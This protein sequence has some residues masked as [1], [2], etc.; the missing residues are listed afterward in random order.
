MRDGAVAQVLAH[1]APILRL[2]LG[3]IVAVPGARF[4]VRFDAQLV[5]YLRDVAVDVLRAIVGMK[6]LDDEGEAVQER[7]QHRDEECLA[8]S[9]AGGDPCV[10]SHTVYGIDRVDA[11]DAVPIALMNAVHA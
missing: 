2:S 10:L 4:G 3:V 7:F 9:L 1:N 8:N 5:E 6:S 11:R